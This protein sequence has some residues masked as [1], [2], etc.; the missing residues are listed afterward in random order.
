MSFSKSMESLTP[1]LNGSIL[2]GITRK[3]IIELLNHWNIP[4]DRTEL[5]IEELV[6]AYHDETLEEAFGTGTAAVISPI[7]EFELVR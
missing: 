4:V 1:A 3:S 2:D 7:G 5:S 6:E